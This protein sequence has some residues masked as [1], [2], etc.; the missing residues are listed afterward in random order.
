MTRFSAAPQPTSTLWGAPDHAEQTLPGIWEVGTPSHGGLILSAERQQAMADALRLDG[1]AY[2]EDVNWCLVVLAFAAEFE[3][4]RQ[5]GAHARVKLA[6]DFARNWHPDRYEA[7]TGTPVEARDSHVRRRR[8]AYQTCIGE[9]VVV[10]AFGSWA[11]WVPDGKVGVVGRRL[12]SVDYLGR[13]TYTG[14]GVQ[15]LV[16][17]DRYDSSRTANSFTVI[18]AEIIENP[19]N[20]ALVTKEVQLR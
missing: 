1:T 7:F 4:S 15:A 5:P 3:N 8:E 19:A 20:A 11:Y 13:P 2:E 10:S 14:E 18:G 12:E 6:H 17:Q 16:D 9:L